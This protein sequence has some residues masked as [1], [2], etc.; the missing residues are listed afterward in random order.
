MKLSEI[1]EDQQLDELLPALGAIG[2]AVAKGAAAAGGKIAQGAQQLGT[3]IAQGA[4]K[5]GTQAAPA[6]GGAVPA[7]PA[8]PDPKAIALAAQQSKE[9]KDNVAQQLKDIDQ[10]VQDLTKQKA[11][12]QK[13][14]ATIK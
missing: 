8:A 3:K 10:Q 12:L 4:Q 1:S 6:P 11:E 2:G 7:Q 5:V 14:L 13:Q 9:Q